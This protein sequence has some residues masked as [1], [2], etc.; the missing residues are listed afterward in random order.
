[1]VIAEWIIYTMIIC[2]CIFSL[3]IGSILMV[4]SINVLSDMKILKDKNDAK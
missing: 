1:M 3:G 2:F 4:I